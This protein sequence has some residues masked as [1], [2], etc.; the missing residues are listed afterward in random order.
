MFLLPASALVL[1]GLIPAS[2]RGQ[3]QDTNSLLNDLRNIQ[4]PPPG[5]AA[6]SMGPTGGLG[7]GL[8]G[9]L[10]SSFGMPSASLPN[11]GG[12]PP[13]GGQQQIQTEI[14]HDLGCSEGP[15]AQAWQSAKRHFRK[16][17]GEAGVAPF[18]LATPEEMAGA[19]EAAMKDLNAVD[20]LK[21]ETQDDCGFGKLFLQLLSI[22]M[23]DDPLAFSEVIRGVEQIAS[24]VLTLLLDIPWAGTA[25]SGWPF[26]GLFAQA[27]LRKHTVP[28][29]LNAEQV[30]GFD[31]PNAQ[32]FLAYL[33]EAVP[34][35]DLGAMAQA[36][37]LY[38][39]APTQGQALGPMTAIAAQAA[40]APLEP[41]IEGLNLLQKS[42]KQ[43]VQSGPELDIALS[44][45]WP[46][47]T[48]LHLAVTPLAV[49]GSQ[50]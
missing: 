26:F 11:M 42:F 34:N 24:P 30:D 9:G 50:D 39:N 8:G 4:F 36:G 6:A 35:L 16:V 20:A 49:S 29:A 47:W 46:L 45:R 44:T 3:A 1:L 5:Q 32:Q 14:P 48:L 15:R 19:M 17:F 23:S 12:L 28:G 7:G 37:G 31:D 27:N 43:V 41:R 21:P 22:V 10:P 2:V 38:L 18:S 33:A 13:L 25:Q 40:V